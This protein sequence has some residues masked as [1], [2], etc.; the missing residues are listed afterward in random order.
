MKAIVRRRYGPPE[1]LRLVETEVP[2]VGDDEILVKVVA[3]SVNPYDGHA[4]RGE[5]YLIRLEDGLRTPKNP[6]V[7]IDVSGTVAAIGKDVRAFKLGDQVFGRGIGAFAEFALSDETHLAQKPSELTFESAASVPCAGVAALRGLR[8]KG[9]VREGHSVLI[10]GAAGGVGTFA[11]QIAKAFGASVTG[12]CSTKNL[13]FVRS[14]G[15]DDVVDYT[16]VDFSR[17][18]RRYDV[19]LDAV[20]NRSL[21]DLRRALK[22][23]G[24][25]VV[26][27]GGTGKWFGPVLLMLR[28]KVASPFVRQQLRPLVAH[29]STVDLDLLSSLYEMGQLVPVIDRTFPLSSVAEAVRYVEAG[30]T[31][32]KVVVVN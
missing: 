32:G 14:I 17:L 10:N 9:M 31:R 28:A 7:G 29:V 11:V 25:L 21:R 4:I 15:A 19:V 5:P 16:V 23:K 12:V 30:H 2:A 24:V 8:D 26:V 22:P 20:G 3:S 6:A 13:E 27:T 1:S 18:G